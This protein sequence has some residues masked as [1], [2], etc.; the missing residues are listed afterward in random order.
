MSVSFEGIG[1]IV[2]TFEAVSGT[3]AG[4]PVKISSAGKVTACSDGD[5]FCG[6]A[7]YVTGDGHAAVQLSGHCTAAYTGTAPDVGYGRL[8]SDGSGAVKADAGSEGVY[9]GGEY[10]ITEVD[11]AAGTVGFWI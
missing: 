10:L 6:V 1:Q 3:A 7:L 11:T 8:V 4:D 5:R 9:T 2:A